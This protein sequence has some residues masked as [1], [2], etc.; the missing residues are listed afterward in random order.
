[1]ILLGLSVHDWYKRE[2]PR[3]PDEPPSQARTQYSFYHG[4]AVDSLRRYSQLP[5]PE[6]RAI[7]KNLESAMVTMEEWLTLLD[8]SGCQVLCLGECHEESTRRFLSE[9]FFAKF[10]VDLLLLEATPHELAHLMEKMRAGRRYYPLLGADI[11]NVLRSVRSRSPEV[12]IYGIDETE[13]QQMQAKGISG[14]R[15]RSMARN[16]WRHFRPG[17]RN[18]VLVGRL[19]STNDPAWLFGT[20]RAQAPDPLKQHMVNAC[21]LGEHQNGPLEALLF[22]MDEAGIGPQTNAF[23]IPDTS[24]FSPRLR[25]WFPTLDSQLL[26]QY[27]TLIVFRG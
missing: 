12:M 1:M 24:A 23:V 9:A 10:R 19:H 14:S 5:G 20:L 13:H 16:F 3:P 27:R 8:R 18:V 11:M 7:A 26:E 22:F 2:Y 4:R 17:K 6:R 15:N 21:V 25:K